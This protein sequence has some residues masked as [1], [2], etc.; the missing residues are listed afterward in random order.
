MMMLNSFEWNCRLWLLFEQIGKFIV[1]SLLVSSSSFIFWLRGMIFL[2]GKSAGISSWGL[3][4]KN[5]VGFTSSYMYWWWYKR[6]SAGFFSVL[7]ISI[8][9]CGVSNSF[10]VF[11]FV[12]LFNVGHNT[13][14]A[15][16]YLHIQLLI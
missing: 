6:K 4:D 8:A 16:I 7:V 15:R 3:W 11:Y 13:K 2:I 1:F 5:G 10:F 12:I 14:V 9:F